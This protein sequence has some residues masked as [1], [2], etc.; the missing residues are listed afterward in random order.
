MDTNTVDTTWHDNIPQAMNQRPW[1][2]AHIL[3]HVQASLS[4]HRC[5][6]LPPWMSRI[7]WETGDLRCVCGRGGG[8]AN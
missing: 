4:V 6:D 1:R 3:K 2:S 7:D 8:G 5:M